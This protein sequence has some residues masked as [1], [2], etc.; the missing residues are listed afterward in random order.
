MSFLEREASSLDHIQVLEASFA[1]DNLRR[2]RALPTCSAGL[3][4]LVLASWSMVV[5]KVRAHEPIQFV[6][7]IC[8][9][10]LGCMPGQRGCGTFLT[11]SLLFLVST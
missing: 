10:V 6:S 2:K 5:Q 11:K 1:P 7:R 3:T 4:V 8:S 9:D